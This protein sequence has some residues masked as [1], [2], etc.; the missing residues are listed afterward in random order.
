M[1]SRMPFRPGDDAVPAAVAPLLGELRSELLVMPREEIVGEH[2]EMM[3][4]EE[5][6]LATPRFV[7]PRAALPRPRR[8]AFAFACVSATIAGCGLSAAGALPKP[9]QRITDTIAHSLGVPETNRVEP[10]PHASNG[11]LGTT[12]PRVAPATHRVAP[13]TST[14]PTP[15]SAPRSHHKGTGSPPTIAHN[16]HTSGQSA[17][18]P[19]P[20]LNKP[21]PVKPSKRVKPGHVVKPPSKNSE[22]TPPGY[23]IDWR[24]RAIAAGAK[25]L[26]VCAQ[27]VTLAPTDCPQVAT[28]ADA[29]QPVQWTLL[30]DPRVGAVVIAQSKATQDQWGNPS[31]TTTVTI[32]ERF[33]MD[34]S[35]TG[36][37]G[38]ISLA[39][40]SGIGQATMVWNGT[41]F[42]KVSFLS[43][44]AAGHLL[45]GVNIPSLVRPVGA[46]DAT[47]LTAVQA[48]FNDCVTAAST[49]PLPT[50]PQLAAGA[51]LNGDPTQGATVTFDPQQGTFA[52]TGTYALTSD[53]GTPGHAYTAT[54]FYDG[55]TFRV[56]GI[57]GS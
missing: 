41:A 24:Q 50:C 56:L 40:S 6:L 55:T 36:A 22:N 27:A 15:T 48:A 45:P 39:Y 5:Q 51:Q 53:A 9:L 10:A 44:S 7:K 11:A 54:L 25:Q 28:A 26:T 12:A 21:R 20:P 42:V 37:G 18:P 2:L 38:S 49:T 16:P 57:T 1:T 14:A 17:T 31:R 52:V 46:T 33:Q 34:A 30:N 3:A 19:P 23:P 43:G 4:F 47:A 29:S 8:A 35:I 32:Y 13:T